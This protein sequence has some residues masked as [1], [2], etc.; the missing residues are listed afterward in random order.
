MISVVTWLWCDGSRDY[1][2]EHVNVLARMIHRRLSV[3][4]QFICVADSGAGFAPGVEWFQTP[5]EA[6]RIGELRTPEGT[7]FPSCYRRLWMFSQEAREIGERVLLLDIDLVA[8]GELAPL[9]ERE[10]DF[11]GWRPRAQWGHTD[12]YG[13]GIYLL[14]TGSRRHVWEEFRG[15]SSIEEARRRGYRGSDQAWISHSLGAREE[16]WSDAAGIYS[17]RDLRNGLL[18]LPRDARI[19]QFNG[20]QKPW[21]TSLAWAR[22]HWSAGNA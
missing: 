12:R 11:I 5:P 2:A 17:I 14:R 4:H 18:P 3:A 15:L 19:V 16:V 21:S 1:R 7:R 6:K 13:G 9:V 10:A 20:P 8:T 22:E